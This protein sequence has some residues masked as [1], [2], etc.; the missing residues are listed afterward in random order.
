MPAEL[1]ANRFVD[2]LAALVPPT[3]RPTFVR[4]ARAR[5]RTGTNSNADFRIRMGSI[6]ELAKEFVD[7]PVGEI[8]KLLTS[9][10]HEVRVGALSIMDKR[11]RR[12]RTPEDQRK[13]LFDLYLRRSDRIDSWDL[14]DLGAPYV[15]GRYLW[16]KPRKVLYRLARSKSP[17][18]RRAAIVSTLYFVRKGDVDDTFALAE[19]LIGDD[20][21]YVQKATGGLLREAG[22]KD[23]GRLRE[24]LKGNAARMDATALRYA[25]EHLT[26]K[27]RD[28][29]RARGGPGRRS[30]TKRTQRR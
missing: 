2:R 11:A 26:P 5:D 29:Y 22:K 24:F 3:S 9:P 28:R 1:S 27:Q 23:V 18:E 8:D 19:L 20:H 25:M 15:I 21:E 30:A 7:L 6:F 4:S 13:E 17:W 10:L 12:N 14:V 16:D